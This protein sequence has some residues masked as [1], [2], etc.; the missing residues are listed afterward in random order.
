M[1]TKKQIKITP[2]IFLFPAI[3][4][5]GAFVF[6][7]FIQSI[8]YSFFKF[9]DFQPESFVQFSNYIRLF[10][11]STFLNSIALTLQWAIMSAIIPTFVG[12]VLAILLE[13]RTRNRIFTGT[14]R[15]ILFL[16]QMMS[17][18]AVGLLWSLIYNPLIG[19][20]S[21]LF[22]ALG[23]TS[24]INPVDLL[25]NTD[26]TMLAAFATMVWLSSGFSMV[27]FSAALQGVPRGVIESAMIDGANKFSQIR[28]I[29]IPY[30]LR[31]VMLLLTLNMIG[32]FKAF[33]V[34]YVLTKGGPGN[35]T[36]ITSLYMYRQAFAA[37][38]FDYAAAMAVV[39]F[40][41]TVFFVVVV[42]SVTD[43]IY[44]RFSH[45]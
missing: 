29:S 36:N 25:G 30:I 38:K 44:K 40:V 42:M 4:L 31:T 35:A 13:Y 19:L 21:G 20:I 3:I 33:D 5:M 41:L 17:M 34:L 2:Y 12:L 39:L 11:D 26:T 22:N 16:P 15:L 9:K 18:V 10:Q 7:P 45:D 14:A 6:L 23:I 24:T 43:R 1:K 32:G 27:I 37:F 8:Q 28:Y